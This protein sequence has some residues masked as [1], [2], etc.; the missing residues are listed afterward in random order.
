MCSYVDIKSY[1]LSMCIGYWAQS[2]AH[3]TSNCACDIPGLTQEPW[4]YFV[5]ES[6]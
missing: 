4:I 5:T 6:Q 2:P 3:K 1:L